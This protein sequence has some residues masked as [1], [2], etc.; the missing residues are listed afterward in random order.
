KGA[1]LVPGA[2]FSMMLVTGD[3]SMG[4]TGTVTYRKG[5]RILGFG[6]PFLG[7]GPIDAPLTSAYIYDVYPLLAGSYKIAS[8]GP[9]VGSS[10]QDRNFAVSG[11]IGRMPH[12]IPVTVDVK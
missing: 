9:V 2:A 5:S 6:H 1:P 4:A 3:V 11:V 12:T 8:P 7:I 10:S